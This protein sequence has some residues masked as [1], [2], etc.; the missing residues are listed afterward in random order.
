M[1]KINK[2]ILFLLTFVILVSCTKNEWKEIENIKI[3][4]HAEVKENQNTIVLTKDHADNSVIFQEVNID[5]A[6]KIE[7][8]IT[9]IKSVGIRKS[10]YDASNNLVTTADLFSQDNIQ[11]TIFTKI[12]T[13]EA[14][15]AGL[16]FSKDDLQV[17]YSFMFSTYIEKNNG[18]TIITTEGNYQTKPEYLDFCTLPHIP[19]GIWE[20][21]N[22]KTSFKKLVEVKYMELEEGVWF[23]VFTDFGIDWSNWN[24]YWYGTAF[25]LECPLSGDDRFVVRLSGWGTDM[26]LWFEMDNDSGIPETRPLRLMPYVYLDDGNPGFYDAQKKQFI[27]KNI[28][29]NDA[30]WGADRHIIEDVTFTYVG[31]N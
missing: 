12:N 10:I 28:E 21:H 6:F 29:V 27:F 30:W 19:A 18:E 26:P 15:M 17:G 13:Q 14:L 5:L 3:G 24:D 2:T 9:D 16:D 8:S 23:W 25:Y 11:D 4:F 22:K 7:S 20:A 1:K 31:E